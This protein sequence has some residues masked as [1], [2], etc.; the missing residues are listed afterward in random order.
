LFCRAFAYQQVVPLAISTII[1][2]IGSVT[3]S[4][5]PIAAAIGSSIKKTLRAP[6]AY[7]ASLGREQF[8]LERLDASSSTRLT[9]ERL[10]SNGARLGQDFPYGQVRLDLSKPVCNPPR[11]ERT[12]ARFSST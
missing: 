2:P 8:G 4:P 10:G 3:G 12:L 5:A 7:A 1:L 6:A 9:A 11:A